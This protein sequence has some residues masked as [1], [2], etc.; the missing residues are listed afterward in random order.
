MEGGLYEYPMKNI[1]RTAKKVLLGPLTDISALVGF[2]TSSPQQGVKY[3][4]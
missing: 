4:L 3:Y 2:S 1:L